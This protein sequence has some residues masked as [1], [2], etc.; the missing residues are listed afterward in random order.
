[1]SQLKKKKMPIRGC[2]V[3]HTPGSGRGRTALEARVDALVSPIFLLPCSP[4]YRQPSWG[5]VHSHPAVLSFQE[6][7]QLLGDP[8]P[9]SSLSTWTLSKEDRW[10]WSVWA[11]AARH[12][13]ANKQAR[14]MERKVCFNSGQTSVQRQTPWYPQQVGAFID[15]QKQHSHL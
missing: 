12:S 10:F 5:D 3:T 15:I 11:L 14:L 7:K 13:N 6:T 1:M 2:D 9:S 4:A 8:R